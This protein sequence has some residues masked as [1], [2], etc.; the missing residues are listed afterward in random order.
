A[1]DSPPVSLTCGP[2]ATGRSSGCGSVPIPFSSP[3]SWPTETFGV[4]IDEPGPV[5]LH[6]GLL[7][8]DVA[9]RAAVPRGTARSSRSDGKTIEP[10]EKMR[11]AQR[12]KRA[13]SA[14][15]GT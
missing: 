7:V 12:V 4:R 11:S 13:P 8:P 3:A 6:V 15:Y 2:Y 9:H 14:M 5:Q 1:R 10:S